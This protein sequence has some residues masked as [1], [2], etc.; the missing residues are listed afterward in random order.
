MIFARLRLAARGPRTAS[1]Q[2][3]PWGFK[4]R[5]AKTRLMNFARLRLAARGAARRLPDS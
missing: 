5:R 2:D 3:P 1:L 4:V